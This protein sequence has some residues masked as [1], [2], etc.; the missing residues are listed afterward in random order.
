MN[1]LYHTPVVVKWH[2][3]CAVEAL[4]VGFLL[5]E[6]SC[7]L[8]LIE[9]EQL[10]SWIVTCIPVSSKKNSSLICK[11]YDQAFDKHI[12]FRQF[13]MSTKFA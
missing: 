9:Y 11:Y 13:N 1:K 5:K 3:P 2:S 8:S 6:L 4:A 7:L 10:S 12:A